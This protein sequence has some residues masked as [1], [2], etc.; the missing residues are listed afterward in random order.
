MFSSKN[1]YSLKGC[2]TP[3]GRDYIIPS[4]WQSLN[5]PK[6]LAKLSALMKL[7]AIASSCPRSFQEKQSAGIYIADPRADFSLCQAL[8]G[9]DRSEVPPKPFGALS[10]TALLPPRQPGFYASSSAPIKRNQGLHTRD[11]G[12]VQN[13]RYHL[14]SCEMQVSDKFSQPWT[15]PYP[16][17]HRLH[18]LPLTPIIKIKINHLR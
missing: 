7:Q 4:L 2:S 10:P 9:H 8:T 14:L 18:P 13:T 5:F 3:R 11:R 15:L 17:N 16:G 12:R 6:F 1:N